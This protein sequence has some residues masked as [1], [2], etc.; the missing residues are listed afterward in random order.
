M[1]S[2]VSKP[3][4]T[5]LLSFATPQDRTQ[6]QQQPHGLLNG[7]A[8]SDLSRLMTDPSLAALLYGRVPSMLN[9]LEAAHLQ[10]QQQ[11][12][13]ELQQR[14]NAAAFQLQ[15]QQQQQQAR[16][17]Q[18]PS[19]VMSEE[20]AFRLY[21]ARVEAGKNCQQPGCQICPAEHYHCRSDGCNLSFK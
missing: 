17:Q 5:G 9:Q 4:S 3:G 12:Q 11:Q 19:P 6:L 7:L 21:L 16:L 13:I 20:D 15:Q 1:Q 8:V 18:S 10:H 2:S 14:V